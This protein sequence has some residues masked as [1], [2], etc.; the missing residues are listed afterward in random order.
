MT[1]NNYSTINDRKIII[2]TCA[3]R[4][5]RYY[6]EEPIFISQLIERCSQPVITYE[7]AYQSMT[8]EEQSNIK[9]C[10]GFIA[11]ALQNGV[12]KK[13]AVMRRT[14]ITVDV[15]HCPAGLN[16]VNHV[17]EQLP[18]C[19]W[20]LYTTHSH[21]PRAPRFRVIVFVDRDMLPDEHYKVSVWVS[22][23]IGI[24]M[25]DPTTHDVNRMMFWPSVSFL[26]KF[27]CHYNP[28]VL[29]N[30]DEVLAEC[31]T[32]SEWPESERER[33]ERQSQALQANPL[34]KAG[35]IGAFCRTYSI[36]AVIEKFLPD[37][38]EPCADSSRYTWTGGSGTAGG[39]VIHDD[40]TFAY[41]HHATDPI[42]GKLVNAFDMVR[43]HLYGELDELTPSGTATEELPSFKEM[44]RLA[45][46]DPETKATVAA[47]LKAEI[48]THIKALEEM[49]EGERPEYFKT[50][51]LPLV[52]Q[53]EP[54]EQ[55]AA[56]DR[57]T[58]LLKIGKRDIARALKNL[59][60][61]AQAEGQSEFFSWDGKF[62]PSQLANFILETNHLKLHHNRIYRYE[63]GIYSPVEGEFIKNMC[64]QILGDKYFD[65]RGRE[66]LAQV[67]TRLSETLEE[68][69]DRLVNVLNGLLDLSGS[70][71]ILQEHTPN[72]FSIVQLPIMYNPEA[73]CPRI[74]KF[75]REV[76]LPD[77]ISL[78]EE[79]FGDLLQPGLT[80]QKATMFIGSG[81]NGK[82][83]LLLLL[84]ALLGV[85]NVSQEPLQSL[86]ENRFR[87]AN[88]D[89]KLANICGDIPSK[90]L[91]DSGVFKMLV[92]GDWITAE[93]KNEPTFVFKNKAKLIFSANKLPRTRDNT[94]G[95]Y[96]RWI[97]IRF[98][99]TFNEKTPGFDPNLLS[100][101]TTPEELS[102]LL[103]IAIW[104]LERLKDRGYY[105]IPQSVRDEIEEYNVEND[106]VKQFL[107]E[108]CELRLGEII[109][110][111]TLYSAY[112]EFCT[113]NGERPVGRMEFNRRL[114][115]NLPGVKMRNDLGAMAWSGLALAPR[116][117]A[118]DD[119]LN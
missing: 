80:Y 116:C 38:Y 73:T 30:V 14:A 61:A 16:P 56:V 92:G 83:I 64:Q 49:P 95:F 10:G 74:E 6:T 71:P 82:T 106:S 77:C 68:P 89:G 99:N 13:N 114:R 45:A 86:T 33:R 79:I 112:T 72:Y 105:E 20:C 97:I 1:T 85:A 44:M 119:F 26:E 40:D 78:I 88:L 2:Y 58:K 109:K 3:K 8:K 117:D 93:R 9:D 100:K 69:S 7:T 53:L 52:A 102:G 54:I 35:L 87:V 81:A 104:G 19:T 57:L 63:A 75:F 15:D 107:N 67:K 37:K 76:L 48:E 43:L 36:S 39:L 27:I 11:G 84:L 96:R 50:N 41:S 110:R 12:R 59:Q 34:E 31:A 111:T 65:N 55:A 90:P 101:L 18:G 4:G 113:Y 42:S 32:W 47:E 66:V 29:L 46:N 70:V 108:R 28:G 23:K 118:Y 5:Q 25:V 22:L 98:P 21:T 17:M 60:K 62:I 91:E 51:L 115:E 24:E 103:N 94:N